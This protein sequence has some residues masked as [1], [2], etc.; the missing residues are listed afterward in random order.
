MSL[1][2]SNFPIFCPP[3][4]SPIPFLWFPCFW[5]FLSTKNPLTFWN[6]KLFLLDAPHPPIRRSSYNCIPYG[7]TILHGRRGNKQR[8][9]QDRVDLSQ[10]GTQEESNSEITLLTSNLYII[11][12]IHLKC[13]RQWVLTNVCIHETA[14]AIKTQKTFIILQNYLVPLDCPSLPLLL[15]VEDYSSGF[16]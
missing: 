16:D 4:P 8:T 5:N 6:F 9:N 3:S 15:A 2:T 12:Y 11:N 7:H 14:A 13:T 1:S 10:Q